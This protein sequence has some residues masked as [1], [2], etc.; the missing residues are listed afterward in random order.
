MRTWSAC[1]ALFVLGSGF[2]AVACGGDDPAGSTP[3]G[4]NGGPTTPIPTPEP[5]TESGKVEP[6]PDGGLVGDA[7]GIDAAPTESARL[8]GYVFSNSPAADE[9]TPIATYSYNASGGAMKITRASTGQYTVTFTGLAL[10]SSVALTSAYDTQGGLCHWV[11]TT[12]EAVQ[13]RCLSAAGNIADAKFALTVVGKGTTGATILGFAHAND[14]GG[15]SYVPQ[16]SRSNNVGG[17]AITATRLS[18]GTYKMDFAG[19]ALTDIENVQVMPYGDASAHCVVKSWVAGAV[20]VH[21]YDNAATLTDAEYTVLVAGKKPGGTARIVAYANASESAS[22]S[23]A[24]ALSYNEGAGAVTATRSTPGTYAI[25]F[26]GQNLTDG[27]HV[28][29]SAHAQGRR[30]N[31]NA[32]TGTTVNLTCT[33]AAGTA[34]DNNYAVVVLQ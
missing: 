34:S 16:A 33:S 1:V 13:V 29:V 31:V 3:T 2:S 5:P 9:S 18:A 8:L 27:A 10:G 32:W 17:G 7:A 30:C 11:G 24:P 26:G 21:C 20:N 22:A 12:G 23:Y 14:K 6:V 19:L 15:A 25:A 4:V 28:Q